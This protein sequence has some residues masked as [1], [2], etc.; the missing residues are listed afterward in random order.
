MIA[1]YIVLS[2]SIYDC[3]MANHD[4]FCDP[5]TYVHV[6]ERYVHVGLVNFIFE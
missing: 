6:G 5:L 4:Q 1:E 3:I 2:L